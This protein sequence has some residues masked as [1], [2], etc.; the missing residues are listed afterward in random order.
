MTDK[1]ISDNKV[2]DNLF[3]NV[4]ANASLKEALGLFSK[5]DLDNIL[6]ALDITNLSNSNKLVLIDILNDKIKSTIPS[7]VKKLSKDECRLLFDIMKNGGILKF[8]EKNLEYVLRLRQYGI[9]VTAKTNF[10]DKYILIP[11]ELRP[12]LYLLLDD[13]C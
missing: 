8:N 7:I 10:H 2:N 6:E 11:Q 13:V 4:N 12:D 1:I 5:P 9:V 3:S